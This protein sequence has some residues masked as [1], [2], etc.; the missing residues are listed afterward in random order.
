MHLLKNTE[1]LPAW[2][3]LPLGT[4]LVLKGF[5]CLQFVYGFS[6]FLKFIKLFKHFIQ[7]FISNNFMEVNEL[8]NRLEFSGIFCNYEDYFHIIKKTGVKD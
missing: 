1:N 6:N 5:F 4:L 3:P 7:S 8:S 2:K